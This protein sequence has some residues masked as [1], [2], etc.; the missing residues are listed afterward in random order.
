M[1]INTFPLRIDTDGITIL[2]NRND[3][4][5]LPNCYKLEATDILQISSASAGSY[6]T[7]DKNGIYIIKTPGLSIS[8][9]KRFQSKFENLPNSSILPPIIACPDFEILF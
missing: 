1:P 2:M 8:M 4:F 9:E 5:A 7:L 3:N 6:T